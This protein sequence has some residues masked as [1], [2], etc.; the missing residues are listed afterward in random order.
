VGP[1]LYLH[2]RGGLYLNVLR[3]EEYTPSH[4]HGRLYGMREV[5]CRDGWDDLSEEEITQFR[6][7][8]RE[9][10]VGSTATRA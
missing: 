10:R 7:L 5:G 2:F 8:H 9:A 1:L 6:E 4:T 3:M